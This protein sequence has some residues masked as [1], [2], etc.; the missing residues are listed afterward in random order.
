MREGSPDVRASQKEPFHGEKIG[1]FLEAPLPSSTLNRFTPR[2][3]GDSLPEPEE[4]Q[5][6]GGNKSDG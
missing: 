4:E 3:H 5:E 1:H 6:H 2:G